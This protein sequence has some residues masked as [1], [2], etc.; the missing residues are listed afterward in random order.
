MFN[1]SNKH[2]YNFFLKK[3]IYVEK[4]V[5]VRQKT[6]FNDIKYQKQ[7]K[8]YSIASKNEKEVIVKCK[9]PNYKN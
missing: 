9:K 5:I 1:L 4:K 8:F 2:I 7:R 3:N 6:H